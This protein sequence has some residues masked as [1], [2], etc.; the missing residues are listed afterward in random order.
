MC[1]HQF[2]CK[3]VSEKTRPSWI[4]PSEQNFMGKDHHHRDLA[5]WQELA[6]RM[7][8]LPSSALYILPLTGIVRE[9]LYCS[10]FLQLDFGNAPKRWV[11]RRPFE[12][13]RVMVM[14]RRR[15][16]RRT[17]LFMWP[18][19]S[20]LVRAFWISNMWKRRIP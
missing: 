13:V 20:Q 17:P 3:L 14:M 15:G 8:I 7:S 6:F 10:H 16:R 19:I 5:P 2:C 4:G 9:R 18:K 11:A 1:L 12:C